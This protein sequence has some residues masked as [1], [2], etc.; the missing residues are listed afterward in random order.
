M[1]MIVN[2]G[3]TPLACGKS[4][5]SEGIDDR[6]FGLGAEGCR[7]HLMRGEERLAVGLRAVAAQTR[8]QIRARGRAPLGAFD[9]ERRV[10]QTFDPLRAGRERDIEE[11]GESGHH[12]LRI[13]R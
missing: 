6:A 2:I 10:V 11:S 8:F 9:D 12:V 13:E 7:A 1:A 5:P 3:L 4:D